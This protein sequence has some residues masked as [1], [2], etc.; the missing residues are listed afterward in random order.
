MA[1]V[2]AFLRV[3]QNTAIRMVDRLEQHG[4][5]VRAR[6]PSSRRELTISATEKGVGL[7]K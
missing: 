6:N 3:D 4:L 5:L 1:E 2:A 7:L